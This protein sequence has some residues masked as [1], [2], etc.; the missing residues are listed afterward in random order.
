MY[1]EQVTGLP[2]IVI[3]FH[4]DKIAQFGLNIDDV[5]QVIKAAFAGASA[6]LVFEGEK[7]FDLVVRLDNQNRQSIDDIKSVFVT[8]PTGHQVPLGQLAEIA[9]VVGPNQIQREDAK[10]RIIV[11]SMFAVVMLRVS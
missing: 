7:R 10:R 5:N 6:G 8:T 2:Q 1:V 11:G 9:F 4:R 3:E